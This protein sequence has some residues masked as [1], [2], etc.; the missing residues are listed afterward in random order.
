MPKNH[1]KKNQLLT[2]PQ[3]FY[4]PKTSRNWYVR[5]VPPAHLKGVPGVEE[6]RKS[7]GHSDLKRARPIGQT[8]IAERLREWDALARASDASKAAPTILTHDLI[9]TI[10]ATRLY[11]WMRND[12][13][14]RLA[15]IDDEQLLEID[16]FCE[17]TDKAMRSILAQGSASSRWPEVADTVLDW[18]LAMGYEVE[19]TDPSFPLLI[20]SFAKVEK[21]AQSR[22]ALRNEGEDTETPAPPRTARHKLSDVTNPFEEFKSISVEKKHLSTT[23]NA[24]KLFIEFSGDIPLDSVTAAHVYEFMQHRMHTTTKPWSE[25]RAKSFGRRVL[26]EIFGFARTKGFMTIPNPIDALEVFPSLSK[27][28]EA[29]R[30]KPR[31]P[32]TSAQLNTLFASDWYDPKDENRFR[33]KMRADLGARYWIPLIGLFHGNR[34]SEALQLAV[35]DFSWDSEVFVVHF[36]TELEDA[37][38]K[39]ETNSSARR[40]G[41]QLST[42]DVQQLRRLK[43][44]AT[45]RVVPVHPKLLEL[46][47]ADFVKARREEGPNALLFP[48]SLP[49][50]GSKNPK[51]GRAYE[52]SFLRFVRDQLGFGNGYGSHSFRHQLEDRLRN[53][54]ARDG[55][56]PPGLS[57][58]YTGRK[59]TREVDIKVTEEQGSE[60]AYGIGY[61]ARWMLLYISQIDF[62]DVVLP[63]RFT[64]WLPHKK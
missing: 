22:I 63:P 17:L 56:W 30:K 16:S 46:G 53:T 14:E 12:D 42:H 35:S 34:V 20:R 25:A 44:T 62:S 37:N 10:C 18:C 1:A 59:R 3:H 55:N 47:L 27:S 33:G 36:R 45:E 49:N 11:S 29:S 5:L 51:L 64:A 26:R 24:W 41:A 61:Q 21:E 19:P 7:T 6:L 2:V 60:A 23:L 50:P 4:R 43:T 38:E 8:L 52:Q 28:D 32:F 9:D 54:Q 48:S 58:Q 39:S 15:G 13:E 40:E 57:Q 31:Y